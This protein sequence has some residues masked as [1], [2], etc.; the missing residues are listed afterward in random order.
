MKR[1]ALSL[2]LPVLG[3]LAFAIA[4]SDATSPDPHSALRPGTPNPALQGNL[5]PP[6]TRTAVDVSVATTPTGG[7]APL[8]LTVNPPPISLNAVFSGVYFANPS[9]ESAAAA[10][11]VGDVSLLT[12]AWLRLD[13]KQTG[14]NSVSANA[15][16]QLT[17][18]KSSGHGT[19]IIYDG[20]GAPH[21]VVIGAVTWTTANQVCD[22]ASDLCAVISFEATIDGRAAQGTADAFGCELQIG[23][24]GSQFYYCGPIPD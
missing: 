24:G 2:S 1:F 12:A 16:F 8:A 5:P 7:A 18:Q 15:R 10:G 20:L 13:N 9:L 11:E 4:C 21:T 22:A 23:E 19:L 6:P 17:D 14:V 3:A